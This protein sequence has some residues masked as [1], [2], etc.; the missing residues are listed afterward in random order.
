MT[1]GNRIQNPSHSPRSLLYLSKAGEHHQLREGG[2]E[3]MCLTRKL[4]KN[5]RF[6][7]VSKF[8]VAEAGPSGNVV[9]L[10]L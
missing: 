5:G 6:P 4:A 1:E 3:P 7:K 8:P 2:V 9:A 10:G